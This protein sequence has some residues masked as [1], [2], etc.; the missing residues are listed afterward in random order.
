MLW[1]QVPP[2]AAHFPLK[3]T[4]LGELHCIVCCTILGVPW[5]E[6]LMY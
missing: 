4:V 5:S 2:E 6:Y 3:M 1:V